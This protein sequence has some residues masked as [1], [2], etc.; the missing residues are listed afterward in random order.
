MMQP[1]LFQKNKRISYTLP[2]DENDFSDMPNIEMMYRRRNNDPDI[3][4]VIIMGKRNKMED[5]YSKL[6]NFLTPQLMQKK[7][8]NWLNY[9][10]EKTYCIIEEENLH[11][12]NLNLKME[13]SNYHTAEDHF[14]TENREAGFTL[15]TRPILSSYIKAAMSSSK[16][17]RLSDGSYYAEIPECPG[18]WANEDTKELCISILREV[19][20]EWIVLKLLDHDPLPVLDGIE[21]GKVVEESCSP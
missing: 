2:Y 8:N 1:R 14:K 20:E 17:E 13:M 6:Q 10:K 18:V 3:I 16:I 4:K 11:Q 9:N 15:E 21:L 12:L 7:R 5:L 19:I